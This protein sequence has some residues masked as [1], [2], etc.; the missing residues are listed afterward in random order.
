MAL[1]YWVSSLIYN[2]DAR[3]PNLFM[4]NGRCHVSV[5]RGNK[6]RIT[7]YQL[8][9]ASAS[10]QPQATDFRRQGGSSSGRA[11]RHTDWLQSSQCPPMCIFPSS[12]G[13][14][15]GRIP[16]NEFGVTALCLHA[17][18]IL[19]IRQ[20]WAQKRSQNRAV[21]PIRFGAAVQRGHRMLTF[22]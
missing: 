21:E 22:L 7:S 16:S 11:C 19:L 4:R 2:L 15:L 14:L 1:R 12:D 9:R 8:P 10:G 6:E 3:K 5:S 18:L 17:I 13:Q 20:L